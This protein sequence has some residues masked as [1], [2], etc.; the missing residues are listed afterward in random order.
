MKEFKA[1]IFAFLAFVMATPVVRAGE[2]LDSICS[3]GLPVMCIETVDHEEPTC[4]YVSHPEGSMGIG[5][6]NVTKVPMRVTIHRASDGSVLYDSGDYVEDVSGATIKLRGNSSAYEAKK[7]YKI[8]LQKKAD[9]LMR[10]DKRFNDK[11]WILITD[12]DV[13]TLFGMIVSEIMGMQWTP[14]GEYV[15]V[16][17]NGDYRGIYMLTEQVKRN[18]DCRLKT[19]KSGFIVEHDPYWWLDPDHVIISPLNNP[20]YNYTYKYPEPEDV[21]E[22]QAAYITAYMQ[23]YDQALQNDTYPELIDVSSLANWLLTHDILGILDSGGTNK[24]F[25]KSDD[26]DTTKLVMPLLWDFDSA[27]STSGVWCRIHSGSFGKRFFTGRDKSM[28]RLYQRRWRYI[29]TILYD[30]VMA[31]YDAFVNSEQGRGVALSRPADDARWG[32][33]HI[34]L[35]DFRTRL[36]DWMTARVD[37][38]NTNVPKLYNNPFADGDVNEDGM[39]DGVDLNLVINHILGVS[40]APFA[41]DCNG[42]AAVNAIDLNMVINGI[43][44]RQE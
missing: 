19:E 3:L 14:R 10:G 34:T 9:L 6:T 29:S 12:D 43:L 22:D 23:A 2:L 4:D 15:N 33:D 13:T 20:R 40:K 31:R 30:E 38:L 11:N 44:S 28:V 24:Y 8:K 26:S 7:P 35:P 39:V 18:N 32:V 25:L 42:D 21:T 1:C 27:L 16:I 37:F 41:A 36:N 5:I 17:F